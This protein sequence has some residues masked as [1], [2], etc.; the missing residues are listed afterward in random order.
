[1][2]EFRQFINFQ[3]SKGSSVN[4]PEEVT[5]LALFLSSLLH[6][7]TK[8]ATQVA[9]AA[10]RWV[11]G[12]LPIK[13]NPLDSMICKNLIEAEKRSPHNPINKK[14]PVD[15]E[16]IKAIVN[17]YAKE[18]CNLKDLRLATMCVLAYA[19][20]FRS[21]ELLEIKI[22]DIRLVDEYLIIFIPK[23]KNDVYRLGQQVFIAKSGLP[24]CP[25]TLFI[26]YL[27]RA[28][29][30]IER[31]TDEYVFR[32]VVFRKTTQSYSLGNRKLSYTRLRE[33]FKECLK[34]IGYNEE[35]YGLHSFR[36]GGATSL[37]EALKDNPSK[38]R[39]LKLQGRWKSDHAKDMYIKES[40]KDRLKLSKSLGL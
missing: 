36:S 35:L 17:N 28:N 6:K 31:H 14:E 2:R 25:Y 16:L 26:R 18:G 8:S 37:A 40:V 24:T 39:L 1:M 29:I 11:H 38:E 20:L 15:L 5:N 30:K 32:N 9:Y 21:Q 23:S 22:S 3:K 19:G 34:R 13:R 33:I 7:N 10:L 4:L 12:I 27:T